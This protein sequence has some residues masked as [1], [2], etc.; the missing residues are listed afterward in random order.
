[1][2]HATKLTVLA[3]IAGST[4][5]T[6][7]VSVRG[8][9]VPSNAQVEVEGRPAE[10]AGGVFRESVPVD[11][12]SNTIDV[13]ASREGADPVTRTVEITRG[14]TAA[15]LARA[16]GAKAKR[17]ATSAAAARKAEAAR[18]SAKADA[19]ADS[20]P[21]SSGC[22]VVPNVV[23]KNHQL[24]QDIMQAA[25]LYMLT[26]EDATGQGRALLFDRNWV[27]VAQDPAAGKCVSENTTVMLSAKKIGE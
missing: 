8:T 19:T 13:V 21:S 27:G 24:G 25:G 1:V 18:P 2:A 6:Q 5:R 10:V 4:I 22:I 23:G 26:E 3:P 17:R 7:S 11:V 15:Q 12:G 14:R 9:V 20:S 16:A